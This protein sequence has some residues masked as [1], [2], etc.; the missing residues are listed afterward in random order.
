MAAGR[1]SPLARALGLHRRP[2]IEVLDATC[3]LGRDSAVLAGLGCR[4]TALERHPALHAL[5]DDALGRA[6]GAAERPRWLDNWQALYHA[7]ASEWLRTYS[8]TP[9]DAVYIDPM[10]E[11]SRRKARPQRAL[12][13]LSQLA[14]ED[15][16]AAAL[17]ECARRVAARR[18]VVK[19]HARA[20]PLAPPDRQLR[21]KAV[22]F[23]IYLTGSNEAR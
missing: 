14:G 9:I 5:L 7:D 2:G 21:G 4:V 1:K 6:R 3:G 22:R 17:L 18:V 23:D 16:D 13:W 12:A 19:Q 20:T 11:S 10:F 15:A 8:G